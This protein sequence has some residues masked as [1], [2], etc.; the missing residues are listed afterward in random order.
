MKRYLDFKCDQCHWI[1][2]LLVEG[3]VQ[4]WPCNRCGKGMMRWLPTRVNLCGL[5]KRSDHG[6]VDG[7]SSDHDELVRTARRFL[8]NA[9]RSGKLKD[10]PELLR[11]KPEDIVIDSPGPTYDDSWQDERRQQN[12]IDVDHEMKEIDRSLEEVTRAQM[13]LSPETRKE[14]K[15]IMTA[16]GLERQA[17]QREETVSQIEV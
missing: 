14:V 6:E 12:R 10:H 2:D 17:K 5:P 3:D 7:A 16:Q 13:N 15:R 11:L 8:Y 9:E 1:E 4:P